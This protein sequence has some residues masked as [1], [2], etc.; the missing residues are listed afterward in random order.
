[1]KTNLLIILFLVIWG[2]SFSQSLES[3][4]NI[5]FENNPMIRATQKR[6]QI[7]EE[8]IN[9]A[10]TIP[11][12]EFSAGY[13]I[14]TPE[15]RVGAQ[16]ARF[17][18]KQ[19][20]PWFGSIENRSEFS[21]SMAEIEYVNYTI[22]KRKLAFSISTIYYELFEI[23][24]KELIIEEQLSLL[25][26]Y[27]QLA[28]NS[29]QVGK[30]SAVDVLKLQLRIN[31]LKEQIEILQTNKAEVSTRLNILL[32]RNPKMEIVVEDLVMFD[33]LTVIDPATIELNPELLKFDAAISSIDRSELLNQNESKPMFG[34]GLDYIPVAERTDMVLSDN[35]KD[36][37][38][39]MVSLS[40]PI[41]NN[42]FNSVSIQNKIK[43][44]ETLALK[45]NRTNELNTQL[46][47]ALK[48]LEAAKIS[49]DYQQQN[50][51]RAK[52]AETILLKTYETGKVDFNELLNIQELQLNIEI[53][54]LAAIK[55]YYKN[56]AEI[57]YLI[58]IKS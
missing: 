1:M 48:N 25:Q 38:M 41:F 2:N 5:G 21:K 10:N 42:K 47:T 50:L 24:K 23:S 18:V 9:E 11:N 3:F 39:P 32:N 36:I 34:L 8:T 12:T 43:K 49:Y 33:E 45:E 19:M 55:K 13:F 6:Y 4:I 14:T 27:E 54:T 28:L 26:T 31:K 15:T 20:F 30:A 44:E 52:N 37:L 17:S 46:N 51:E 57:A 16:K 7:A 58:E 40:I 22:A 53:S 29:V 56:L 35:G